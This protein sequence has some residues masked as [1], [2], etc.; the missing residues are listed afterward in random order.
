[1][2][3]HFID[4]DIDRNKEIVKSVLAILNNSV[5]SAVS[6]GSDIMLRQ[7][8]LTATDQYTQAN[9]YRVQLTR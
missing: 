6:P 9:K 4:Y 2:M 1:M 8:P 7:L 5:I 3:G